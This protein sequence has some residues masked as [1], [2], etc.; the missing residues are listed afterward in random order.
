MLVLT[1]PTYKQ[2]VVAPVEA[3][4]N[5]VGMAIVLVRDFSGITPD[6]LKM[7]TDEANSRADPPAGLIVHTASQ[8]G[9]K[10]RVIDVWETQ[11]AFEK[12]Q[13]RLGAAIAAVAQREGLELQPPPA[14]LLEVFDLV[15]GPR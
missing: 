9:D 13:D 7:V 2:H 6:H 8:V 1:I 4:A 10:I 12:F 14:E 11:A 15:Q 3:A 5:I